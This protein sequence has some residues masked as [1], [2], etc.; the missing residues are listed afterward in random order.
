MMMMWGPFGVAR[1][2]GRH[3]YVFITLGRPSGALH[4][5]T[6]TRAHSQTNRLPILHPKL[7]SSEPEEEVATKP[8]LPFKSA[9]RIGTICA[10]T[11]C[12]GDDDDGKGGHFRWVR[13]ASTANFIAHRRRRRSTG[14]CSSRIGHHRGGGGGEQRL[15]DSHT[16]AN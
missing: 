13:V 16:Q 10:F 6:H 8:I 2:Y 11:L 15:I 5:Q 4:E 12:G 3:A 14:T 1:I 9:R 7:S